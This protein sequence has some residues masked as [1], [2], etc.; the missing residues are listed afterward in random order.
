MENVMLRNHVF[1]ITA[2]ICNLS[3]YY[4][5]RSLTEPHWFDCRP[6]GVFRIDT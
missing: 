5:D 3:E 6:A 2:R 1:N 4:W